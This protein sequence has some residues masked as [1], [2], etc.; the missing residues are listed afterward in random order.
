MHQERIMIV[1]QKNQYAIRAI[2]ELACHKGD[3]PLKIADI[4]SA[5]AIPIR[6]LEVILAK[7]K[8]SGMVASKR[9]YAG[10]YTLVRPADQ[11]TVVEVLQHMQDNARPVRCTSCGTKGRCP[12]DP[13]CVFLP[14]WQ[15]VENAIVGVLSNTTIA[16]LMANDKSL[17]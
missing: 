2:Y 7:M 4:A 6:F 8:R 15:K 14:M 10:G 3:Q 9:G 5:Q 1:T 13:D 17:A 16:D 11:I 12:L